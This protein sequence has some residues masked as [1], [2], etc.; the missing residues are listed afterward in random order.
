MVEI[1]LASG[2]AIRFQNPQLQN[3]IAAAQN[4]EYWLRAPKRRATAVV[5]GRGAAA[6]M[7]RSRG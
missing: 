6:T 4:P 1:I 7:N 2:I 3:R 5:G